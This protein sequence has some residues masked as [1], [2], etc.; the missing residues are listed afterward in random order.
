MKCRKKALIP[1]LVVIMT[2]CVMTA[3]VARAEPGYAHALLPSAAELKNDPAD[4]QRSTFAAHRVKKTR[5]RRDMLLL[6]QNA[7]VDDWESYHHP[8]FVGE[9]EDA[10]RTVRVTYALALYS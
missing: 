3:H 4:E 5:A 6:M 1:L 9:E 10:M 2:Y 8:D 7:D